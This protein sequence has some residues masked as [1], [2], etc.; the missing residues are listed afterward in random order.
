M[1][2]YTEADAGKGREYA[3][4]LIVYKMSEPSSFVFEDLLTYPAV[5]ALEG[6]K[7]HDVRRIPLRFTCVVWCGV[8]WCGVV[9]CGVVWCGVV[10]CG[11]VWCGVVW[12]GVVWCGV[13]WCEWCD[14]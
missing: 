14:M 11:V 9:W 13:V 7:I 4:E 12:C 1:Q 6:E 2:T 5:K 3:K 10:W 8:V